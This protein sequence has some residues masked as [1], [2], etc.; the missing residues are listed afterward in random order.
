MQRDSTIRP[1]PLSRAWIP[2]F[3]LAVT[4]LLTL[5]TT[6]YGRATTEARER[7]RFESATQETRNNIGSRL[8]TYIT[9]LRGGAGLFAAN[10]AVTSEEFQ[11][12]VQ[13]LPL[14][15][16]YPG[17]QGIGFAPGVRAEELDEFSGAMQAQ[18]IESFRVWPL[19]EERPLYYPVAYLEPPDERNRAAIGFDM[20]S[21]AV[22]REAMERARDTGIVAA[23]GKVTLVQEP[24]ENRQAGFLLYLPVYRGG[25]VPETEA[26]RREAIMGFV[27]SPFRAGDLLTAILGPSESYAVDFQVYDGTESVEANLLHDSARAR[28]ATPEPSPRFEAVDT[29]EVAGR[30]WTLRFVPGPAFAEGAGVDLTPFILAGGLLTSL[31]LFAV[32]RAQVR[33][34]TS[35]EELAADLQRS[36]AALRANELRLRRL[37]DANII[38]IIIAD[39]QGSIFEANDA[40]LDIVGYTREEVLSGAVNWL[41]L[42][43]PE[44]RHLDHWALD[45][46]RRTGAHPTYEKEYLRKDGRRVPIL[47]GAAYLGGSEEQTVAFLLDITERKQAE[48]ALRLLAEAG[49]AL[50]TSLDYET[51]LQSLAR[52]VV[53][54][55]ADYSI[56]VMLNDDG[57][58]H[59]AASAHVDPE[60]ESM[61]R[62][63]EHLYTYD[64]ERPESVIGRV[65]RSGK[66]EW[67]NELTEEIPQSVTANETVLAIYRA[68]DPKAYMAVPLT[69]RNR[70]LGVMSLA[71]S[72]SGRQY[73]NVE[74]ALAE[75]LARRA[76]LAIDN[77]RLYLEAQE[78]IR[79]RDQFLSIASHDLKT[80]ITTIKGYTNLLQRRAARD[81]AL[82][83][84][85]L[86]ALRIVDEQA[87][88]L[89]RLVELLLDASRVQSGQL[90][91]ERAP[92][93]LV[94]L[95]DRLVNVTRPTLVQHRLHLQV[96]EE[97]VIV[98]GDE[99]RLEQV[100]QNLLSN[101]IKYSP[102]GGEIRVRVEQREGQA[103]VSVSDQG[104]G[105]PEEELPQ[106]F[107][108][109]Y[110][111]RNL[112]GY[113]IGGMGLG[114]Y[115]VHYIVQAHGGATR[116]TSE[117][118][119]GSTFEITLPLATGA[120]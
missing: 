46:L 31:A 7:L 17:I 55:L 16:R 85:Y 51:T 90:L 70:T 38:G 82:P 93:N 10:E 76:A 91:I 80:P 52:L 12:F 110:R 18:G 60:R 22:R 79:V 4:L 67:S 47:A 2:S 37:V 49:T 8:E 21:E 53:P 15:R 68:L 94:V 34:R 13:R 103:V 73:T 25:I 74:L 20:F 104:L 61:L 120:A 101:A 42:T 117:V 9:L 19:E 118:G 35:A 50:T 58:L 109:F 43:P 105:I 45:E 11:R 66:P 88:R 39:L 29:I 115:I 107:N 5:A 86:R 69:A 108:R 56:I 96:P 89:A 102:N 48:E 111:A 44:Y 65:I 112:E 75:E 1:P 119:V 24:E 40:F 41:D 64:V 72:V 32:T 63:L 95:A 57:E 87:T 14:E 54:A 3:V 99:L 28:G 98:E 113:E 78:A 116:V 26:A 33:A 106:L 84:T 6:Y 81:G 30:P 23:T 83:E 59:Q 92:V 27:Y 36:Q 100:L 62:D 77:A 71:T 97:P 114:L